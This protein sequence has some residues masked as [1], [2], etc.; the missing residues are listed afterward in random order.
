MTR[1]GARLDVA[2][3]GGDSGTVHVGLPDIH[4]VTAGTV[5]ARA[6]VGVGRG[7][8]PAE[9]VSLIVEGKCLVGTPENEH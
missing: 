5:L 1:T 3:V 2:D 9:D 8:R 6:R 7:R 4:L